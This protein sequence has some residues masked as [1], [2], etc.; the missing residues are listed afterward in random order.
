MVQS[1][2]SG[3]S[4]SGDGKHTGGQAA[5]RRAPPLNRHRQLPGERRDLITVG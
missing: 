4:E 3:W 2:G 5:R 1:A